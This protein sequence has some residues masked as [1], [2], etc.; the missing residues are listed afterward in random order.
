MAL[1]FLNFLLIWLT[2]YSLHCSLF[3]F[4][5]L[6]LFPQ[7][8]APANQTGILSPPVPP[9][10][11]F[12]VH[13]S[14]MGCG[15]SSISTKPNNTSSAPLKEV[16]KP[17]QK[18]VGLGVVKQSGIAAVRFWFFFFFFFLFPFFLFF[19]PTPSLMNKM[20]RITILHHFKNIFFVYFERG[21][22]W[23]TSPETCA[24]WLCCMYYRYIIF[25]CL[26]IYCEET[27]EFVCSLLL[28]FSPSFLF[29]TNLSCLLRVYFFLTIVICR[30]WNNNKNISN[31][32]EPTLYIYIWAWA[33]KTSYYTHIHNNRLTIPCLFPNF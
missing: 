6:F 32:K 8:C 5:F 15:P 19:P 4:C 12:L 25:L 10:P 26:F 17:A 24:V 22:Q 27:R 21:K 33:M 14:K 9:H 16:A 1:V 31:N 23:S 13:F 11:W 7:P 3:F 29:I 30:G 2:A 18:P 28:F 20:R